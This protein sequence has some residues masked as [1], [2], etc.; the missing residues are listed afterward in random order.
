MT[1]Q[2]ILTDTSFWEFVRSQRFVVVHFGAVWNGY[3]AEM[4]RTIESQ[5]PDHLAQKIAFATL[6][7]DPPAHHEIC[8]RHQILNVPFLAFYRD[9]SLARTSTGLLTSDLLIEHLKELLDGP[10]Q[11]AHDSPSHLPG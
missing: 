6:D 5:I 4:R 11:T 9:G 7:I 1:E 3:D 2:T 10:A 8:R